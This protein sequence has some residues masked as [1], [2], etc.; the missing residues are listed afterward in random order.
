[1]LECDEKLNLLKKLEVKCWPIK[2]PSSKKNKRCR[3]NR[4]SIFNKAKQWWTENIIFI[5]I[6]QTYIYPFF[7]SETG[8]PFA[9][10]SQMP[11]T[12]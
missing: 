12:F 4:N 11:S 6:L 3:Q 5:H 7:S 10:S 8:Q 9:T 1:M 2:N